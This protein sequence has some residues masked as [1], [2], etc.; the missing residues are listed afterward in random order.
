L[1]SNGFSPDLFETSYGNVV[2]YVL[3]IV[4]ALN[5]KRIKVT[6]DK[7]QV[8]KCVA[9]LDR[10]CPKYADT[11]VTEPPTH[12]TVADEVEQDPCSPMLLVK[13][14]QQAGE[15][16]DVGD[17]P[18]PQCM[19]DLVCRNQFED[20]QGICA[21]PA[22]MGDGCTDDG[23]CD[24]GLYCNH[25]NAQCE[26]LGGE[27]APCAY[28][29]PTFKIQRTEIAPT[30]DNRA[31]T[32]IDCASPLTCDPKTK[33]C[34][35]PCSAGVFCDTFDGNADCPDKMVC[36]VTENPDLAD[37][38]SL[39]VCRAATAKGK[40][41]TIGAAECATGNCGYNDDNDMVCLGALIADGGSCDAAGSP[42]ATCKSG[43][44]N[45]KGKCA[46][47]CVYDEMLG[48][49]AGCA[50][51]E[52]CLEVDTA[53]PPY[54]FCEAKGANGDDCDIDADAN[55][56]DDYECTS[57]FCDTSMAPAE[58][59][60]DGK[61]AARV[62]AG[63]ACASHLLQQCPTTQFCS[64]DGTNYT[65]TNFLAEGVACNTPA[66]PFGACGDPAA[67]CNPA[68]NTCHAY[69]DAGD[70]CSLD[71]TYL[72]CANGLICDQIDLKCREPGKYADG[73]NCES[74]TQCL[75][76]W[77]SGITQSEQYCLSY[78]TPRPAEC[79]GTCATPIGDGKAC[80]GSDTTKNRCVVTDYCKYPDDDFAGKCVKR[81]TAGQKCAPR[82]TGADCLN[83]ISPSNNG[84]CV[85]SND[86][87]VCDSNAIPDGELFCDGN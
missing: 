77:C 68:T 58:D 46:K 47:A 80:D 14:L 50:N 63:A 48:N 81:L 21:T 16:C 8:D 5:D 70:P 1:L 31:A 34:V 20:E 11:D 22:A 84:N 19:D 12:C 60:R 17:L 64:F 75:H 71:S 42:D 51:T 43:Y 56:H 9:S 40:P 57:G 39:G 69:G 10:E 55:P 76:G 37:L 35:T 44:C 25:A 61:C 86:S 33:K 13:G 15:P 2:N 65:C 83:S 36:N 23:E 78:P 66:A 74:D 53:P 79:R 45:I 54:V 26:K 29:D 4:Q 18:V 72:Y 7:K 62:A 6:I 82:F 27:G 67:Y 38:W 3:Q 32:S 87:F 24:E 49:Y 52:Y 28:I 59:G 41:C 30:G 73:A 85:F